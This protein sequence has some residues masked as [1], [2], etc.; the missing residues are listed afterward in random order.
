[1]NV[2]LHCTVSYEKN[3]QI[4]QTNLSLKVKC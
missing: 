1:M 3:K 4:Q 2:M